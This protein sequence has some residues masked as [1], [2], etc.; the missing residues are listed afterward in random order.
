MPLF[1]VIR[2][3]GPAWK[4]DAA[5]E[6]QD[7]WRRHADFMNGLVTEGF[8]KLGGPLE[9]TLDVLLIVKAKDE[10]EIRERLAADCWSKKEL[11]GIKEISPWTL[12]LGSLE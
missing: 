7:D 4:T 2:T 12:R 11:L 1:A 8:V 3:R 5:L 9:G 6:S 10:Q